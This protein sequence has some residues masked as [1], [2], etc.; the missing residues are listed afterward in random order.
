[1]S[2]SKSDLYLQ[3]LCYLYEKIPFDKEN[4]DAYTYSKKRHL[5]IEDRKVNIRKRESVLLSS[6]GHKTKL[7]PASTFLGLNMEPMRLDNIEEKKEN[8][9]EVIKIPRKTNFNLVN[10]L[11]NDFTI[12]CSNIKIDQ[13]GSLFESPSLFF[14]NINKMIDKIDDLNLNDSNKKQNSKFLS[15]QNSH[16]P[17]KRKRI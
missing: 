17:K 14:K 2:K 9:E 8:K 3:L 12:R 11:N 4:L 6:P 16:S 13:R 15:N 5:S 10:N 7:Q 1:M